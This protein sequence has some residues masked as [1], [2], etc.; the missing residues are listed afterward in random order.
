MLSDATD[1][2]WKRPSAPDDA[3]TRALA[4]VARIEARP[5]PTSN[6]PFRASGLGK[7]CPRGAVLQAAGAVLGEVHTRRDA[8]DVWALAVG[9]AYHAAWQDALLPLLPGATLLGWWAR[10]I[11]LSGGQGGEGVHP[12]GTVIMSHHV[13]VA[14]GDKQAGALPYA[15]IPRPPGEGWRYVELGFADAQDNLTGHCDG[16]LAWADGTREVLELKTA[17]PRSFTQVD[18]AYGGV[19]YPEHLVQVQLYM[20]WAGLQRARIVYVRK[21][22]DAAIDAIA[23]HVVAYDHAVVAEVRDVVR[24]AR[25]ALAGFECWQAYGGSMPMPVPDRLLGCKFKGDKRARRCDQRD[26]CFAKD[27]A[28]ACGK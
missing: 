20:A 27:V 26:A 13:E 11:A 6:G 16:V 3:V 17:S 23:E 21:E 15:A 10:D 1:H 24:D 7:L 4:G 28:R 8:R 9:T 2:L 5:A 25:A 22:A 14:R 12:W 19:P 18:G